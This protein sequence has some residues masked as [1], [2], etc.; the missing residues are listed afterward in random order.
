VSGVHL[1]GHARS[2]L[3]QPPVSF[4]TLKITRDKQKNKIHCFFENDEKIFLKIVL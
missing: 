2:T 4:H 1:Q 3:R